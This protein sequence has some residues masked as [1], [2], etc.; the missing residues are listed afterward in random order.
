MQLINV[1]RWLGIVQD[2]WN[3]RG[4][5]SLGLEVSSRT[6]VDSR[7]PSLIGR[8]TGTAKLSFPRSFI[9]QMKDLLI[10]QMISTV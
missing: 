5:S 7:A 8:H 6:F 1:G 4:R 9:Q 10:D 2:G 3:M